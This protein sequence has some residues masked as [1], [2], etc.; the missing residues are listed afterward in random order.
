[1]G[2]GGCRYFAPVLDDTARYGGGLLLKTKDEIGDKCEIFII[3]AEN[4]QG[5]KLAIMRVDNAAELVEGKLKK[6]CER[7]GISYEKIV[8]DA[9]QQNGVAERANRTYVSMARAMLL[10]GNVSTFFWPLAIQA[11]VHIKNRVPH[12]ALPPNTTPYEMWF[13]RKPDISHFRPFGCKVTARKLLSD[14]QPKLEPRGEQGI[15]MGYAQDAQGYLIWFPN[16]RS[17]RVRR[18]V[19]FHDITEE[20]KAPVPYSDTG[21][22]WNEMKMPNLPG[23]RDRRSR[24][25]SDVDADDQLSEI[26]ETETKEPYV[27]TK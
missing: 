10:D 16:S 22:L 24:D 7:R 4:I 5:R 21:D 15:F 20:V 3:A 17:M 23:T 12:S 1:M 27:L 11:A 14:T 18:D 25:A 19:I 6:I 9:S 13:G 8:P 26:S 2:Y